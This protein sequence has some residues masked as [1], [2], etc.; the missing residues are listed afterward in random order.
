MTV[1]NNFVQQR[2]HSSVKRS[3]GEAD[4]GHSTRYSSMSMSSGLMSR[5]L[6]RASLIILMALWVQRWGQFLLCPLDGITNTS[7]GPCFA[8]RQCVPLVEAQ[9]AVSELL[10]QRPLDDALRGSVLKEIDESVLQA[11][12]LLWCGLLLGELVQARVLLVESLADGDG[13][14]VLMHGETAFGYILVDY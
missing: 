10:Q 13:K 7:P 14:S 3:K 2:S 4:V 9:V 11:C 12:V 1:I 8:C 6:D 5:S